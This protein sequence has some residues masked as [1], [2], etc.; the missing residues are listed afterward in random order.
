MSLEDDLLRYR[1]KVRARR[2]HDVQSSPF[3]LVVMSKGGFRGRGAGAGGA[4]IAVR[5]PDASSRR[6][7][8]KA[9]YIQRD[10]SAS[11]R[12]H[13]AY[14]ERD[15]MERDGSQSPLY[16]PA[17]PDGERVTRSV[18]DS[19]LSVIEREQH[20]FRFIISPEDGAELDLTL[21]TRHLMARVQRDLGQKLIWGAVN[22]YDTAHPHVHVTMRGVDERGAEVRF[23]RAYMQRGLRHQAQALATELLGPR[24]QL[25]YE[26]QR[27]REAQ[28]GR[29]TSLDRRIAM[30]V[31]EGVVSAADVG[32]YER[33]RLRVLETMQLAERVARERWRLVEGW[34]AQLKA[35]GERA[36]VIKQMHRV[37]KMGVE[38]YHVVH[39]GSPLPRAPVERPERV[40]VRV[41]HKGVSEETDAAFAIVESVR[42]QGFYVPLYS[43]EDELRV[44]ELVSLLA[45]RRSWRNRLDEPIADLARA[46]N[47]RLDEHA[48]GRAVTERLEALVRAGLARAKPEQGWSLSADFSMRAHELDSTA[49]PRTAV[50]ASLDALL[51]RTLS[52][53]ER[54]VTVDD[55]VRVVRRRMRE[56]VVSGVVTVADDRRSWRVPADVLE[57]VRALD[58]QAPK[59]QVVLRRAGLSLN[60]QITY[61]GPTWLDEVSPVGEF[62]F[63]H[64]VTQA[65]QRRSVYLRQRGITD[66]LVHERMLVAAGVGRELGRRP[67]RAIQG[68]VGRVVRVHESPNGRHYAVIASEREVVAVNAG[69][70][71]AT[72][73]V[74]RVVMLEF[75]AGRG[76]KHAKLILKQM[77]E[78]EQQPK[79]P[80][81]GSRTDPRA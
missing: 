54:V 42:G 77:P 11:T 67:V 80:V 65:K 58:V 12:R 27:A 4:R 9:R 51:E 3:R 40:D 70:R 71:E 41:V 24:S 31:M 19:L 18:R 45:Q 56:L 52:D 73:L 2:V 59:H 25:E 33:G 72:A 47:E 64:D 68:F 69:R 1:P 16:G 38:R 61:E 62:G 74:G 57:R 39:R 8:V 15:G 23:P 48:L 60:E 78:R 34:S 26:R 50:Q 75:V 28:E 37:L 29:W 63:P 53:R 35:D 14:V 76:S 13:L 49:A 43:H 6:V 46:L 66:V 36:D 5:P 17:S 22:H 21:Y 20:Q 79:A 55:V 32:I 81:R 44:G 10:L 30:R 7:L